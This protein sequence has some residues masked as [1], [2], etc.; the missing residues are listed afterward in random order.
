MIKKSDDIIL[1][2]IARLMAPFLL[3]YGF[4]VLMHGHYSPGGG[5]QAGVVLGATLILLIV[6][7]GSD[8]VQSKVS[9]RAIFTLGGL[10]VF[11]YAGIGA[12]CLVFGGNVLDY[13]ALAPLLHMSVPDARS[14]GILG[15]EVGVSMTVGTIMYA[16]FI[17]LVTGDETTVV[18]HTS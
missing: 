4:Y 14:Y 9:N 5:F 2:V 8:Y 17:T 6:S 12:L 7:M 15:V 18:E 10:G 16:I 13:G 3:T 11:I 1:N